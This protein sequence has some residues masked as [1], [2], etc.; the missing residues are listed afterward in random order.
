MDGKI[1]ERV[2]L[3]GAQMRHY[4][5]NIRQKMFSPSQRGQNLPTDNRG[6]DK[7][8]RKFQIVRSNRKTMA[9]QIGEDLS[10]IVR[11]PYQVSDLE[12]RR[13]VRESEDWIQKHL[14]KARRKQEELR[15]MPVDLLSDRE[16]EE[17]ADQAVAY[18]PRK[19]AYYAREMKVSYGKITIRNQKTRWGSCSG[20]GNLNFN[21]LLMLMPEKIIDYVIVHELC[22]RK[23]M[24]HSSDFWT[25]VENV[26]PDY[27]ERRQWLK[28]HGGEIMRRMTG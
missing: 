14:E 18:I 15:K 27:R 12:V 10:L 28:M 8:D 3:D 24:N 16:M 11:A 2:F 17:L 19:T 23:E 4:N 26:L 13:F 1:R 21:C 9:L 5:K 7:M 6:E 20:K 22:H 25:E